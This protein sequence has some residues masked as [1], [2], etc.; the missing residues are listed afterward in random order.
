MS[1]II[2]REHSLCIDLEAWVIRLFAG[3]KRGPVWL[4]SAGEEVV[5]HMDLLR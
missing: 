3:N 1:T 2:G 5:V 4:E